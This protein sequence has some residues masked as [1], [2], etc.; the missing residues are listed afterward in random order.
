[1]YCSNFI[2]RKKKNSTLKI[3]SSKDESVKIGNFRVNLYQ[4]QTEWLEKSCRNR[5]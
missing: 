4:I 1:M 5:K 3:I 2:N